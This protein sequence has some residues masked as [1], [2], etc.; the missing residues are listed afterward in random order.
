MSRIGTRAPASKAGQ[1]SMAM[2]VSRL[3]LAM[4]IVLIAFNLRPALSS[5]APVLPE[6][7]AD[8]GLSVSVA[9]LLSTAPV[10]CLG[11]F[12]A[13]APGLARRQG[14]ERAILL[15]LAAVIS[16]LVLRA[17]GGVSTLILGS[18]AA[19]AGIG[20]MNVLL[21]SLLKRDFSDRAPLMTGIYSMSL[22]VGAAIA[23]GTVAPLY[24]ATGEWRI[25][26]IFWAIPAIIAFM[27]CSWVWAARLRRRDPVVA[28]SQANSLLHD[29]L[30]WQVTLFMGL[31]SSLA[32]SI[33]AWLAPILR[34]RGDSPVTAGLVVSMS[35][36]FQVAASLPVPIFAARMRRQSVPAILS[37]VATSGGFAGLLL[38]PLSMQWVFGAIQGVGMG[39]AF[40]CAVLFI[41]MRSPNGAAS[42]RLSSMSQCIGY[43]IASGGP[44]VIGLAHEATGDWSGALWLFILAGL[45]AS[46][47]GG[48]AGRPKFVRG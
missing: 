37:M 3:P 13:T 29:P 30:A 17:V 35:V 28:I 32:Y 7:M 31:Q 43:C 27:V 11:L 33:F 15:A 47:A 1:V 24:K 22:C 2:S 5:L 10:L 23:A 46:V 38:A 4:A 8:T 9:S 26:L 40:A 6:I 44:L 19:G 21:P 39:G 25:A 20:I 48:L 36:L 16:G 41:V 45:A 14:V 12:A 18:L 34:S 42:A